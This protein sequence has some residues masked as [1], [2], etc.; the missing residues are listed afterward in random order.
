MNSQSTQWKHHSW[1]I[2]ES[3][4]NIRR[5]QNSAV[6][7][8]VPYLSLIRLRWLLL[9]LPFRCCVVLVVLVQESFP[10][11]HVKHATVTGREFA[12]KPGR[13]AK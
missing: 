10:K 3:W 11:P 2:G 8:A 12:R 9:P 6:P 4:N 13:E 7:I 5:S 1:V